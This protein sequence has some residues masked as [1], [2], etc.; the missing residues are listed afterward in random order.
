MRIISNTLN[1]QLITTDSQRLVVVTRQPVFLSWCR[2]YMFE[3][4]VREQKKSS[5]S[6][7]ERC[8][9][10]RSD[11][12]F[13]SILQCLHYQMLTTKHYLRITLLSQRRFA[14]NSGQKFCPRMQKLR[15]L[16]LIINSLHTKLWLNSEAYRMIE[17]YPLSWFWLIATS[18]PGLFPQKMGEKSPGD[19]VGLIGHPR[20][21]DGPRLH[22]LPPPS[23][24]TH[25]PRNSPL[26]GL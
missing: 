17:A 12:S 8:T 23:L 18:S 9:L 15:R 13:F 2:Q 4:N 20:G 14:R 16:C 7:F 3:F 6:V 5:K 24:Y 19:E 26:W 22:P 25:P 21:K 10:G 11:D 1:S